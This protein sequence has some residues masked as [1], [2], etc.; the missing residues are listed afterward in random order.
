VTERKRLPIVPILITIVATLVLSAGSFYGCARTYGTG[1]TSSPNGFF[2][3][4]FVVF[5]VAF[6]VSLVWL[7][8]TIM[9]N[10]FRRGTEGQ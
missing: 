8:V 1:G 10:F 4:S 7:I 2:A 5:A 6:L 9:I 3:W